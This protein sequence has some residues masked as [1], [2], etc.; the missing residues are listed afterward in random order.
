M[1][2]KS[3]LAAAT[4]VVAVVAA[5]VA[6]SATSTYWTVTH[7]EKAART[8][9]AHYEGEAKEAHDSWIA[10]Q[11]A[12]ER[13]RQE[14]S[15]C[16]NPDYCRVTRELV[17]YYEK[18]VAAKYNL[19]RRALKGW[20]V[21]KALCEGR[22]IPNSRYEFPEFRCKVLI[23]HRGNGEVHIVSVTPRSATRF[24]YQFTDW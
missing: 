23:N 2:L 16:V 9:R 4:T 7:A 6:L 3:K 20:P 24:T 15:T 5:P 21:T 10:S 8:I 12:L 17:A 11:R 19:Y 13:N 14:V 18:K 1:T 22:G